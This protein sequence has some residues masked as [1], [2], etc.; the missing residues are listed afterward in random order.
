MMDNEVLLEQ[1]LTLY[2][3]ALFASLHKQQDLIV[4]CFGEVQRNPAVR[5]LNRLRSTK[6]IIFVT[7][8]GKCKF[9]EYDPEDYLFKIENR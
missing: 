6:T 3:Q 2:F 5:T 1:K 7:R 4:M 9:S 8:A